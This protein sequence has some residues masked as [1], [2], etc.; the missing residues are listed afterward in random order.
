MLLLVS[1]FYLFFSSSAV[2]YSFFRHTYLRHINSSKSQLYFIGM[3]PTHIPTFLFWQ[4]QNLCFCMKNPTA[5]LIYL[6]NRKIASHR[7][8]GWHVCLRSVPSHLHVRTQHIH[9]Y[10]RFGLERGTLTSPCC[11]VPPW[12]LTCGTIPS[13]TST[14]T[15]SL[16]SAT[17]RCHPYPRRW[18]VETRVGVCVCV[19]VCGWVCVGGV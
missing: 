11:S 14:S 8:A 9:T 6:P 17:Y 4:H 16:T 10:S 2:S 13:H 12:T 15:P 7:L 18:R 5:K 3:A 19:S 1:F